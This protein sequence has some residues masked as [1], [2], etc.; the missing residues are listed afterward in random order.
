MNLVFSLAW[1]HGQR[2]YTPSDE[3]IWLWIRRGYSSGLPSQKSLE[4][5]S[6]FILCI[7]PKMQGTWPFHACSVPLYF[8]VYGQPWEVHTML[9]CCP[10][11]SDY[12]ICLTSLWV[13]LHLGTSHCKA[14]FGS[15]LDLFSTALWNLVSLRGL[16]RQGARKEH[17]TLWGGKERERWPFRKI[18]RD[19]TRETGKGNTGWRSS[20]GRRLM[21][22][23]EGWALERSQ[24]K[25][26]KS[27]ERVQ[28]V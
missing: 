25:T 9:P 28:L 17:G 20:G 16:I 13:P 4:M 18:Q 21:E 24:G 19:Q 14:C 5:Y 23:H 12:T 2:T 10:E 15:V 6:V 22:I 3:E 27:K 26:L 11:H 1:L 7:H 8:V